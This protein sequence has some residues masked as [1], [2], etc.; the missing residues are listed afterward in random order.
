MPDVS[1][2]ANPITGYIIYSG[3]KW[4]L[5][6]GT[7][8]GAP[9][10]AAIIADADTYSIAHGGGRMG[11]SANPFFY[12]HAGAPLFRDITV[13]SNNIYGQPDLYATTAGYDMATGLGV[14]DGAT[15][16]QLLLAD[17]QGATADQTTLT[18]AESATVITPAA[19]TTLHGTL[20][21]QTTGLPLAGRS[22]HHR[23]HVQLHG[24]GANCG[25]QRR[26]QR[27]RQLVC[28]G[29]HRRRAHETGLAGVLQRRRRQRA[30]RL[31]RAHAVRPAVL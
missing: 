13:G 7:S 16:A 17:T 27:G 1:F 23:Q 31:R 8:A 4:R 20:T 30:V 12:A 21:D 9:L 15:L 24:R 26:D 18:G 11:G 6:G 25:S 2:D 14:P 19:G 28:V 5:F 10:L 29:D 3:G 22:D